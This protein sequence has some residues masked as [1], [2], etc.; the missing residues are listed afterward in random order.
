MTDPVRRCVLV[1][2]FLAGLVGWFDVQVCWFSENFRLTVLGAA[3]LAYW[4]LFG[5]VVYV[6]HLERQRTPSSPAELLP[7]DVRG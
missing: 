4:M 3:L 6:R 1:L 2:V 5:L 7:K